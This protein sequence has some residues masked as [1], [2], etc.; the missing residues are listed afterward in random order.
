MIYTHTTTQRI[1][2]PERLTKEIE[3][4][5]IDIMQGS[6]QAIE[7]WA[8]LLKSCDATAFQLPSV[9]QSALKNY[10]QKDLQFAFFRQ[11]QQD[12]AALHMVRER[13]RG[14][15]IYRHPGMVEFDYAGPILKRS[16]DPA[17]FWQANLPRLEKALPRHDLM[18]FRQV[19]TIEGLGGLP[20]TL[21]KAVQRDHTHAHPTAIPA[22][23]DPF[24]CLPKAKLRSD[25]RRRARKLDAAGG[26]SFFL[27]EGDDVVPAFEQLKAWRI[28]RFTQLKKNERLTTAQHSGFYLSLATGPAPLARI[29][30]LKVNGHPVAMQYGLVYQNRYYQLLTAFE[31]GPHAVNAPARLLML[32]TM[33]WCHGQGLNI[34]DFTVGDEP[35]KDS[36]GPESLPVRE[37]IY[38]RT[39]L[40]H[41]YA[42]VKRIEFKVEEWLENRG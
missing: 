6:P 23:G 33:R 19:S 27:A 14:L 42:L 32:E 25:L 12:I 40:G 8:K 22:S 31:D 4:P 1:S 5:L 11:G 41:M 16:I 29:T 2:G 37:M 17:T 18:A 24:D 7:R 10:P 21:R 3:P 38:P 30:G 20:V 15:R 39:L 28:A 13:H 35:Y 34:Y 26:M 36:F 9:L